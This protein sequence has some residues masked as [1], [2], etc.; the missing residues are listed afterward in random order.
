MASAHPTQHQHPP[1]ASAKPATPRSAPPQHNERTPTHPVK[2]PAPS[3][4]AFAIPRNPITGPSLDSSALRKETGGVLDLPQTS[5]PKSTPRTGAPKTILLHFTDANTFASTT[6]SIE[7]TTDTY[8]AE[9]FAEG[10]QRLNLEKAL[11]VLKVHGTQTVAPSDRTV[12]ALAA[13]L[14]LDLVR[15]RFLGAAGGGDGMF[16]LGL[17][18]SPGSAGSPNAPLEVD[19]ITSPGYAAIG[20]GGGKKGRG[21][22]G[23][24]GSGAAAFTNPSLLNLTG[25][26]LDVGGGKKYNFLRKQPLSFAPSDPRTLIISP[27]YLQILPAAPPN[28]PGFIGGPGGAGGGGA[29]KVTNVPMRSIVGVKVSRKHPKIVRVLV[30]KAGGGAAGGAEIKRYDLECESAGVAAEI[31]GDV[32]GA[33]KG[34]E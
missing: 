7:T 19:R 24:A 16:G 14:K 6:L 22:Y 12:E 3:P 20:G 8:I 2:S 32:R 5:D 4:P 1:L 30:F 10:C 15:R 13:N 11:Y 21:I 25:L 23:G 28:T 31:V 33:L 29:G 26:G 9:I 17:S 18:G 34:L 27:E